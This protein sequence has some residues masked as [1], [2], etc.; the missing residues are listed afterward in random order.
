MIENR[1]KK[2][3]DIIEQHNY[4]YYI[5]DAPTISDGEYDA[6]FR[7]LYALETKHPEL[8]IP[9]S[10][11]QRVGAEPLIEFGTEY[12][13]SLYPMLWILR[14]LLYSMNE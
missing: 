5:L 1:L 14:S 6:I 11:T 3:R 12:L 4:N 2:L 9:T 7:D 13:C 8:I 10:P